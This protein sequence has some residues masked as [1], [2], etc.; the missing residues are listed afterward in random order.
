M[1][2]SD[3]T[4][5]I[6]VELDDNERLVHYAFSKRTCGQGVG[7]ESLLL[8]QLRERPLSDLLEYEGDDFLAEYPIPDDLEEFLSLKHLYAIKSALEVFAGRE[9]GGRN[10]PFALSEI[11]YQE[12]RWMIEGRISVELV[13]DRI[14]SCGGCKGCGKTQKTVFH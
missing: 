1:P 2:C 7:A 8:D 3:V 11:G 6:H 13:T 14:K 12:G 10:E 9:A 4:E 5:V